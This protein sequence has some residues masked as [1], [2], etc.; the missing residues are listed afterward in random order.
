M[1][2]LASKREYYTDTTLCLYWAAFVLQSKTF[3]PER[4]TY[5]EG[6]LKFNEGIWSDLMAD[7]DKPAKVTLTTA[8]G[9]DS[10]DVTFRQL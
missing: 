3:A 10:R 4:A 2:R 8:A 5:S 6:V 9:S 7:T 1:E